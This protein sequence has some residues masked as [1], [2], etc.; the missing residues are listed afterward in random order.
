MRLFVGRIFRPGAFKVEMSGIIGP[1]DSVFLKFAA[2]ELLGGDGVFRALLR[3]YDPDVLRMLGI[4]ITH[5]VQ[6]IDRTG[7]HLHI[8]LMLRFGLRRWLGSGRTSFSRTFFSGFGFG[9]VFG[10]ALLLALFS[11]GQVFRIG[12]AG[13]GDPFTVRR[14]F[15]FARATRQVSDFPRLAASQRKNVDLRAGTV[16]TTACTGS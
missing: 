11:L 14:P 3:G 12:G 7:N 1:D 10:F 9:F 13:E 8:A 5:T 6:A 16:F 2:G 15:R 4:E